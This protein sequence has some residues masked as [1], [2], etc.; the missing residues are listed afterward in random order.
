LTSCDAGIK[1][2]TTLQKADIDEL[3][4]PADEA[5]LDVTVNDQIIL[6]DAVDYYR[7]FQRLGDDAS[8]MREA[9]PEHHREFAQVFTRQINAV[10]KKL[11]ALPVKSWAGVSCQPFVFGKEEPDW[12]DAASLTDK[13]AKLLRAKKSPSLSTVRVLRIFDG[14]FVFLIKPD[15]LRF[16]LKSIALRDADEAMADLRALGF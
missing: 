15:R 2:S 5:D 6:N 9:E 11:R 7:D 8:V 10:H 13:L 3:P 14:P 1:Q 16:W 12:T 4:F